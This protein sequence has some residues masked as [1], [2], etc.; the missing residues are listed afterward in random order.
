MPAWFAYLVRCRDGSLYAG[1]T[2]D[3]ERRVAAHNGRVPGGARYTRTRR[4]VVLAW[5]SPPL[6][7]IAAHRLE[8][9]LK[10][11]APAAKRRLAAG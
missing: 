1:A 10:R 7:K 2:T 9:R 11:L 5:A 3:L 6:T 4:P 8:W